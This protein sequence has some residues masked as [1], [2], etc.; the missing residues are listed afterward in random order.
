MTKKGVII[1]VVAVLVIIAAIVIPLTY[2]FMTA[3][4]T[5]RVEAERQIQSADFRIYSYEYFFNACADINKAEI[6]Y[7]TQ[8]DVLQA[9]TE[10]TDRYE[11]QIRTVSVL[12][13]N[14]EQLKTDYN[15][16][17]AMEGTRGQFRDTKLPS[18]INIDIH[19]YETQ[20]FLSREA[21]N[22]YMKRMDVPNK[23][24]YIYLITEGGAYIGYH[25]TRTYP[26][27]IA[28]AMSNPEQIKSSS[29]G[30]VSIPA[31]GIDGVYYN[32]VDP[33][34]YYA[35]D[36]ETDAMILF[37]HDFLAYDKPLDLPDGQAPRLHLV[38]E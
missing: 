19:I 16:D 38:L 35:F 6:R 15:A 33:S 4:V 22:E 30:K 34:L 26:I 21:I 23:L 25:I 28:V 9:L 17:A 8:Y 27:S 12:Y 5:G 2:S 31:P 7:D 32:G 37:T 3:E 14:I 18:R 1:A 11:R 36:A 20:N 10:G 29:N 24:W 13:A